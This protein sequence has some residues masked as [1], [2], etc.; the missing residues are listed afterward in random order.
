M[1]LIRKILVF[2]WWLNNRWAAQH[3]HTSLLHL[4]SNTEGKNTMK[5]KKSL[6]VE[7][8]SSLM[9]GKKNAKVMWKQKEKNYSSSSWKARPQY[10]WEGQCFHRVPPFTFF[11]PVFIAEHYIIQNGISFGEFS[12]AVLAV[13]LPTFSPPPA[14]W[15]LGQQAWRYKCRA[16]LTPS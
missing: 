13:F 9:K 1:Y 7:T 14:C 15:P 12:S 6:W 2:L 3:C 8:R 16:Q 5:E 10:T 4:L 11:Q